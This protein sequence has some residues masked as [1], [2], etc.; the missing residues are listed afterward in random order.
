MEKFKTYYSLTKPGV[1][2]GNAITAVAGFLLASSYLRTFD[3]WRFVALTIGMTLVIASAC[4]LNN[5]LD[6]DID[7]KME[8]TRKRA[9]VRGALKNRNAVIFSAVL[10]VV[11]LVMLALMTNWLVVAI[12][13]G[14]FVDYVVLYGML[15]KRLSI[16]GTLV[17]A[18]SGAAPILGGYVAAAGRIDAGAVI[19]FLIIFLWQMPEFYSISIYR[20]EE[21]KAAGVPVMAVVVGI[22]NTKLQIFLYTIAYVAATLLLSI[23][24]YAG[25]VYFV[26]MAALGLYWIWLGAKGFR[27]HTKAE[28]YA[29]ARNMFGFSMITILAVSFM[30]AVGPLL[31]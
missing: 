23:F 2:Y 6:Q 3:V 31:P 4:A 9:M 19:V 11:G 26:I 18:V 5:V 22:E 12:G 25:W 17:G 20:R 24:G 30:V 7:A 28:N 16:H 8:R 1:T 21:Y 14:G 13:I 10:G 29:W 27:A 15:S